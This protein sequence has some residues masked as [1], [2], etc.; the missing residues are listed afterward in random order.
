MDLDF[1]GL[2]VSDLDIWDLNFSDINFLDLDFWDL[3]FSDLGVLNLGIL[4][5]ELYCPE[6]IVQA[7]VKGALTQLVQKVVETKKLPLRYLAHLSCVNC[8]TIFIYVLSEIT[9]LICIIF[10]CIG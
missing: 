9:D 8:K 2:H 1:W 6:E 5:L 10:H 7:A 3:V 4:D